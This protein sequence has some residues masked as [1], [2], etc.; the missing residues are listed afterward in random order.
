MGRGYRHV[1]STSNGAFLR[2]R[3]IHDAVLFE[4]LG[5]T[6]RQPSFHANLHALPSS[7]GV[8]G[9]RLIASTTPATERFDG[10]D[11]AVHDFDDLPHHDAFHSDIAW[12]NGGSNSLTVV[13]RGIVFCHHGGHFGHLFD[14]LE[15]R[16]SKFL[17]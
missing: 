3:F 7:A 1:L 11:V 13:A 6:R 15:H 2:M 17:R 12:D 8:H 9:Q 5:G 14:D 4:L 10:H 16:D